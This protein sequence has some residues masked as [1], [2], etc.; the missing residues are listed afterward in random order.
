VVL[1]GVSSAYVGDRSVI[2]SLGLEL[3]AVIG[4]EVYVEL[5]QRMHRS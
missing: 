3:E 1:Y 2:D 5:R 4:T